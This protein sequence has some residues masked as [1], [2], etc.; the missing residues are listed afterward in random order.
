MRHRRSIMLFALGCIVFAGARAAPAADATNAAASGGVANPNLAT[1]VIPPLIII[2]PTEVR[3][4]PTL[5][6]GCWVRLFPE[7]D[8]KG[9]DDL[10]IAGPITLPSLHTPVG[11]DW[12]HKTESVLVGP[13][14][15]VTVY[16]SQSYRDKAATL[17]PG[18]REAQLRKNL[19]FTMSIDSLKISCAR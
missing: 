5:A 2:A 6:K 7:P 15:T 13:K 11:T 19:K 10:T 12:K 4:D 3:T 9:V 14:A 18:T 8:F 1:P 17:Q 16:E